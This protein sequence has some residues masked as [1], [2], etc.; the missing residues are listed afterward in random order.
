V[1]LSPSS[2]TTLSIPALRAAVTGRVIAPGDAE[3]DAARTVAAGGFD[4]RPAVIVRVADPADVANVILSR[5]RPAAE[6]SVRSG[7]LQRR[8][9]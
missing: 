9:G 8:L 7:K 3:Y 2:P 1:Q 4:K 6:L 5:G